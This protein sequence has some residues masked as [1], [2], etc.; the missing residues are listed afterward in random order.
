M[1][2]FLILFYTIS[3]SLNCYSDMLDDDSINTQTSQIETTTDE[4]SFDD[5][6]M[7]DDDTQAEEECQSLES[8]NRFMTEKNDYFFTKI[9]QP[10]SNGYKTI[11][12]E[13]IRDGIDNFF[14][15]IK[16]PL[17]FINNL[18]Q[19]QLV[20]TLEETGVF[21][22]NTTIGILGIFKPAQSFFGLESHQEDFGQTLGYYGV[23]SGCHIVLPLLGPSNMRDMLGLSV[24]TGFN[25]LYV[26]Y[27][28][29]EKKLKLYENT[30]DEI[31]GKIFEKLNNAPK[32]LKTYNE[33]KKDAIDLYPYLRDMY[34][35][36]RQ[37]QIKE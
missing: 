20:D 7:E 30:T 3:L 31:A 2:I 28:S 27:N 26:D 25:N 32:S 6:F 18:L 22:I 11:T 13:P 15:N 36:S 17:R 19:L 24:D 16:F 9:V 35:Q 29:Q 1:K 10:V 21:V 37:Q 23:E 33:I 12:N 14:Y 4:D 5:D 34:E 8:Y